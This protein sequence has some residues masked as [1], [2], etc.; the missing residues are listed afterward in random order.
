[1]LADPDYILFFEKGELKQGPLK[2][3]VAWLAAA[4]F[5]G[6]E[7]NRFCREVR[8]KERSGAV[9]RLTVFSGRL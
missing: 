1:M 8:K 3:C 6:Y 5:M 9:T 7:G 2:Y 4:L